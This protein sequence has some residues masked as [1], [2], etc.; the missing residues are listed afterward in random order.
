MW[1]L[2]LDENEDDYGLS[3][4]GVKLKDVDGSPPNPDPN[5]LGTI[6]TNPARSCL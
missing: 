2:E 1:G 6:V 3:F 5:T 4:Y